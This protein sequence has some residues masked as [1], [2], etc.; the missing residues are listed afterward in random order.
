T[1]G[2]PPRVP[3]RPARCHGRRRTARRSAGCRGRPRW[4]HARR[5]PP[6]PRPARPAR[7]RPR[8]AIAST[9]RQWRGSWNPVTQ[10]QRAASG[11]AARDGQWHG[12]ERLALLLE[13][14]EHLELTVLG[15]RLV[16]T[17][18]VVLERAIGDF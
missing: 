2:T 16:D 14:P 6:A 11:D 17:V 18:D 9:E 3:G 12:M 13:P 1:A 8:A 15:E 5:R 10:T 4:R 7:R